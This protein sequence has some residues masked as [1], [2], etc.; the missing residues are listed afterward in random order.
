MNIQYCRSQSFLGDKYEKSEYF[1]E[2]K[3]TNKQ[4]VDESFVPVKKSQIKTVSFES[5]VLIFQQKKC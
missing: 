2:R 5:K 4:N 3:M 1:D